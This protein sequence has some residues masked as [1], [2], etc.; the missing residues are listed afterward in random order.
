MHPTYNNTTARG[1]S[2]NQ[3]LASCIMPTSDRRRFV[4]QAIAYFM[5]QDYPC[6]ELIIADDGD[7]CIEDLIPNSP[8]IRYLRLDQKLPLGAKRNLACD[9]AR[10]ALILHWDDDDWMAPWRIRYQ[11][12]SLLESKADVCGLNRLY[13]YDPFSGRSWRYLYPKKN[14]TLLAGGSLCYKKQLWENNPFPEITLGEDTGFL[15]EGRPKKLFPHD[16][17]R[18][19]VALIH[20]ANTNPRHTTRPRWSVYPIELL[21]ARLGPDLEFYRCLTE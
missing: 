18:F 19:Y 12:A 6:K 11:V 2:G 9:Q 4:S 5:R 3:P 13:F 21:E 1:C 20:P 16:D 17:N 7:D 8:L 10:G 14:T 15:W